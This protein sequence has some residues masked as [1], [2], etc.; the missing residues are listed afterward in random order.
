MMIRASLQK[1]LAKAAFY[2]SFKPRILVLPESY[3]PST[4]VDLTQVPLYGSSLKKPQ[5]L[6]SFHPLTFQLFMVLGKKSNTSKGAVS[7]A[8]ARRIF[9]F[10]S[11]SIN[12][13]TD[14]TDVS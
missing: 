5:W 12:E 6:S 1:F 10:A 7:C 13:L 4:L 14:F 3:S 2:S 11:N 9:G 8:M